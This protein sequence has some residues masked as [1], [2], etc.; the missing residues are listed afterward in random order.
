MHYF[1]QYIVIDA[2]QQTEAE[3]SV[4]HTTQFPTFAIKLIGEDCL[5]SFGAALDKTLLDL[6]HLLKPGIDIH[7]AFFG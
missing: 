3:A 2:W 5:T 1:L 7:I 4:Y 6:K